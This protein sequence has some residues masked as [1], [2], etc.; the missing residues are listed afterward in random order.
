MGSAGSGYRGAVPA[1][2]FLR[3]HPCAAL[4]GAQLLAILVY[5]F[6]DQADTRAALAAVGLVILA[7]AVRAVRA[8]PFLWWVAVLLAA[9]ALVLLLAQLVVDAPVLFVWTSGFEAALY[10]YAA[11]SM[12]SY[13]L[14]DEMVTRDELFATGAVFTLVAWAFAYTFV[15][16]QALD[17]QSFTGSAEP[18]QPRSWVELL[19]LSV[20]VLTSLGLSDVMPVGSHARSVVMLEQIFGIFYVALVV[21][22]LITLRAR[23]REGKAGAARR[24]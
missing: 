13:M 15:V 19:Y 6:A 23:R 3:D 24:R 2:R 4:L 9:P 16:V 21:S 14:G 17:P 1:V 12:L 18:G 7:L 11:A 5:P 20:T 8:T 10:F 22:W